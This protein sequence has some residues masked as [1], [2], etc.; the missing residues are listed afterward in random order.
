MEFSVFPFV[1]NA[2][3]ITLTTGEKSLGP[4]ALLTLDRYLYILVRS[5]LSLLHT[6]EC[7]LTQTPFVW[8][9]FQ[10]PNHFIDNSFW[11]SAEPGM[12]LCAVR[13]LVQPVSLNSNR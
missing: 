2:S 3:F 12:S 10:S 9:M 13:S 1:F 4:L 7:Q 5:P 11:L 8:Q 6:K